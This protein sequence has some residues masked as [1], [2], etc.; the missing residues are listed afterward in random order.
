M[1]GRSGLRPAVEQ[2]TAGTMRW[3]VRHRMLVFVVLAAAVIAAGV[4]DGPV[5]LV[6]GLPLLAACGLVTYLSWPVV[7][8][9]GRQLRAAILAA[10]TA[11]VLVH[12][13]AS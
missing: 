8:R 3:L 9:R 6:A 5:S 13:F 12:A 7:D 11:A 2:A 4:L 1:T 10:A